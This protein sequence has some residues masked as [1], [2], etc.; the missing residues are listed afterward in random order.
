V[1]AEWPLIGRDGD[2]AAVEAALEDPGLCGAVVVGADGVG[3]TR[4]VAEV[5]RRAHATGRPVAW[6]TG[7][8]AARTIPFGALA[9][10]LPDE[11]TVRDDSLA[12]L[13]HPA[14]AL[15]RMVGDAPASAD[16]PPIVVVDDAH[17]LDDASITFLHHLV[18]PRYAALLLTARLGEPCPDPITTLWKD[19]LIE[20][21]E[22]EPL[23]RTMVTAVLQ[24]A[25]GGQVDPITSGRIWRLTGGAP[26][27]VREVLH[28]ALVDGGLVRRH[29]VWR[30]D[31]AL[32]PTG[33]LTELMEA[34]L[35]ATDRRCRPVVD[36]I[37]CGEPVPAWLADRVL[38]GPGLELAHSAGLVETD[39][40]GDEPVLRLA[41]PLYG[42][43]LRATAPAS[44]RRRY[45]IHLADALLRHGLRGPDDML[46]A[47]VWTLDAGASPRDAGVSFPAAARQ[48][49][50][51]DDPRLA[52]RLARAALDVQ[53]PDA[54]AILA[55]ALE[56]QGR[57][58]EVLELLARV[59]EPSDSAALAI[60]R[61]SNS[62]WGGAGVPAARTLLSASVEDRPVDGGEVLATETWLLLFDSRLVACIDG[63]RAVMRRGVDDVA[64]VWA[65]TAGATAMGLR[66]LSDEALA[67]ADKGRAAAAALAEVHRW[68]V[69]QVLWARVL[70]LVCAGRLAEAR[71]LVDADDGHAADGSPQLV[72][73]WSGFRGLVAKLQGD[74]ATA[75]ANLRTAVSLLEDGDMYGFTQLWLAE[76]AAAAALAGDAAGARSNLEDAIARHNDANRIFE[77]WIALDHAWVLVAEGRIGAAV[78]Q[79]V[80]AADRARDAEQRAF[81]V[82]AAYDVARLGRP[83]LVN[84]RLADLAAIVEGPLAAQC[85]RASEALC[86][87]DDGQ[88]IAAAQE[89]ERL[90]QHL[91]AAELAIA[92]AAYGSAAFGPGAAVHVAER[93]RGLRERCAEATTPLLATVAAHFTLTRREREIAELAAAGRTSPEI[94][95]ALGISARTVDNHLG[96]VYCKLGVHG[97]SALASVFDGR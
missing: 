41:H 51:R 24:A 3:K 9:H 47:A 89:A 48:A 79:A 6:A 64:L 16:R 81:E 97:R 68:G 14:R 65:A 7:I 74:T 37:A 77:P 90:G 59:S 18:V 40:A 13:S 56:K 76:L 61:A 58:A 71:T 27:F 25:L 21:I 15:A 39:D 12:L 49:L 55:D 42:E 80:T 69:P 95:R 52:E 88:L 26:L 53:A 75:V 86:G 20:R 11:P 4:L 45:L 19:G 46:Q 34:R 94:G 29:D 57:H 92:A 1:A 62:Y 54:I 73:M 84:E 31:G 96:R 83:E 35:L 33:R 70:A 85:A 36:Q 67:V 5:R 30:W 50:R 66:G 23:D 87:H 60:A 44:R 78:D 82:I 38:D 2:L 32:E 91:V 22:L 63:A 17:L 28:A 8:R 43:L 93:A 72:G 10:L